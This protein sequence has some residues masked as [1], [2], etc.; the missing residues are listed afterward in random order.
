[1][2]P[3]G[4][5][6]IERNKSETQQSFKKVYFRDFVIYSFLVGVMNLPISAFEFF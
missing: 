4:P 1:M 6:E 3:L 5:G 2:N